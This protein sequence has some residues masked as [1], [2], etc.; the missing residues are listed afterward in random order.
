MINP[1]RTAVTDPVA[2][3][4]NPPS[5]SSSSATASAAAAQAPTEQMFLQ[6]LVSQIKNQDPLNPTDATQFVGE[7]AQFSELEQVIAM[8]QDL[9]AMKPTTQGNPFGTGSGSGTGSGGVTG[10]GTA[11]A[12]P[13]ISQ[14]S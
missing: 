12:A 2:S 11:N 5:S 6:L 3:A 13:R 4:A 8:R 10:T 9:D 7:L 1:I 14:Q